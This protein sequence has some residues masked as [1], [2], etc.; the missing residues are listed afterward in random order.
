MS[1]VCL[2]VREG[3]LSVTAKAVRLQ[4]AIPHT[5]R[6]GHFGVSVFNSCAGV[7]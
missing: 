6:F 7:A 2:R 4:G 5:Y 1:C 3:V